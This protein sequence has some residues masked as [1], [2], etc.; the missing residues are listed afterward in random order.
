MV[1]SNGYRT[2]VPFLP[3]IASRFAN[4]TAPGI[5]R[6][7][8]SLS[9][10]GAF[11]LRTMLEARTECAR[12]RDGALVHRADASSAATDWREACGRG[13]HPAFPVRANRFYFEDCSA[14]AHERGIRLLKENL[15]TAQ[16]QQLREARLFRGGRRQERQALSH[17]PRPLHEYRSA[18]QEWQARLRLVF[19]SLGLPGGG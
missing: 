6:A 11:R 7:C 1:F 19:F 17:P 14:E 9:W 16:R 15:T 2:S 3:R 12:D 18:R 10:G 5:S 8:V 4:A 13:G